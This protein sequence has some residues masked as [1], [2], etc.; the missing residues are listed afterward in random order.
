MDTAPY[1]LEWDI[2]RTGHA[3]GDQAGEIVSEKVEQRWQRAPEKVEMIDA[4]L[5]WTDHDR[6]MALG[7]LLENLGIDAAVR[8][9]DPRL[10]REA[11]DAL[12]ATR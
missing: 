3:W 8:F 4:R 7:L 9:G 10:W 11:L 12:E 6:L 2:R 5:F 1:D